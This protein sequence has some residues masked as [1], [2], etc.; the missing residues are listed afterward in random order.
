MH[1]CRSY[2]MLIKLPPNVSESSA[3]FPEKN[4]HDRTETSRRLVQP[5]H[6]VPPRTSGTSAAAPPGCVSLRV[7]APPRAAPRDSSVDGWMD[8]WMNG[9]RT[10]SPTR[11]PRSRTNTC[12]TTSVRKKPSN[13][14]DTLAVAITYKYHRRS[15]SRTNIRHVPPN[16]VWMR[17]LS[18]RGRNGRRTPCG[19]KRGRRRIGA[20]YGRVSRSQTASET[21]GRV[22]TSPVG[23]ET[24]WPIVSKLHSVICP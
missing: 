20:Q 19:S 16:L 15:R 7:D 24:L 9:W 12:L 18:R 10:I 11:H 6:V 17:P 21:R 8:E 2:D 5:F 14:S 23:T 1:P 4:P 22:S 13:R 3:I